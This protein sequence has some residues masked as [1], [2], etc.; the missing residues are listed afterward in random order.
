MPRGRPKETRALRNIRWVEKYCRIPEGPRVGQ[1]IKLPKFMREDF[2]LI[3]DNPA[4]PGG[5]S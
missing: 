2:Y 5:R 3:Y 1:E 4:G